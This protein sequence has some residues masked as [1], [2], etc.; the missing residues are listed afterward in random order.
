LDAVA[1]RGFD[2]VITLCDK[3]REVCPEFGNHPR[4][5][6]WSIADPATD[7]TDQ[8]TYPVFTSVAAEIDTRIRHLLP[9]LATTTHI[10]EVAPCPH[11]AKSLVSPTSST[12]SGPPSTSTPPTSA[13][14][15]S[16]MPPP[17]SQT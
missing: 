8:D 3:V 14:P 13:L 12:T 2:Y 17:L 4:L 5:I 11:P 9:V 7:S 1:D 10:R 15:C 6:H 16:L